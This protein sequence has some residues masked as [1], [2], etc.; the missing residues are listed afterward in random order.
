MGYRRKSRELALQALFYLEAN[1]SHEEDPE[2]DHEVIKKEQKELL[3]NF[4]SN[5]EDEITKDIESFFMLLVKGVLDCKPE[6]DILLDNYSKNWK[7]SRMSAVDKNIMRIGAFELLKCPDIP[8]NV[9]I[10]EAVEIGKKFGAN[11]SA[12]F[13]NGV[14]DQL[15][16]QNDND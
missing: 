8:S 12:S 7:L 1:K 4:C 5:F 11:E 3:D 14:L 13:I 10:N 15:H 6:L 9:T 16:K 2:P